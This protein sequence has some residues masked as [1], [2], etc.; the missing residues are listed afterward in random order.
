[1]ADDGAEPIKCPVCDQ[2]VPLKEINA[3][4]DS[5]CGSATSGS[6][7]RAK[8]SQQLFSATQP[9]AAPF[10]S[11]APA[12]V[13]AKRKL[14]QAEHDKP[15]SASTQTTPKAKSAIARGKEA[16]QQAA[17]LAER[18]RPQTLDDFIGQEAL[19]GPQGLLRGLIQQGR[20]PSMVL[21]GGSGTGKTTLARIMARS[22]A[23]S[24]AGGG[25]E[26]QYVFRELSAATN[27]VADCKKT[28]DE[29]QSVLQLTGRRTLVFLDEVHRFTK[30][31]QD[32]FLPYVERGTITLIAATTENPS[33]RINNALV[34]RCR[35]FVLAKLTQDDLLRVLQRACRIVDASHLDDDILRYLAGVADGDARQALNLL[36]IVATLPKPADAPGGGISVSSVR[37]ALRRTTFAYDRAGDAHYDTISAFHKSVR[38][39]DAEATLYYLGRMLEGGEDPLYIA[40][41]MVRIASEDVGLADHNALVLCTA[42]YTA[43]QQVGMPEADCSLAQAAVYLA[44]A[45]KSVEL[46]KGYKRVKSVLRN[47][48]GAATAPIPLHIRNAPTGLMREL[49]YG[50]GYKYNPDHPSGAPEQEYLPDLLRGHRFLELY[51]GDES[52]QG[53][54]NAS[55]PEDNVSL[56][57]GTA[58]GDDNS[59]TP[60]G[61]AGDADEE[62]I[63]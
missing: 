57:S 54:V 16:L 61:G 63:M 5:L 37:D 40:R 55:G 51:D 60:S 15:R 45:P 32:V 11:T 6:A 27:N 20:L 41:R 28:F 7:G 21:W 2:D 13:P 39:S 53:E 24:S 8:K 25:E 46:Y 59:D 22:V 44:Q 14:E 34:S 23:G 10:S 18:V 17:P 4:L 1:M 3:H 48:D 12:Q 52:D 49:G 26:Q 47:M 9:A 31:Q 42:A 43:V 29:A 36:E 33:F 38:G 62:I 56:A 50:S 19:V 58:D 30:S 35:V